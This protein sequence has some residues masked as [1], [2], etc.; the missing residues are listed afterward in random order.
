MALGSEARR[1]RAHG[2]AAA[3]DGR[4]VVCRRATLPAAAGD[5]A[6]S[7]GGSRFLTALLGFGAVASLGGFAWAITGAS[8]WAGSSSAMP[9]T[10]ATVND[11]ASP[12]RGPSQR[13]QPR[14]PAPPQRAQPKPITS[15]PPQMPGNP[16]APTA[17]SAK[18]EPTPQVPSVSA[19]RTQSS[20]Q[21]EQDRRRHTMIEADINARALAAARRNVSVQMYSTSWCRVCTEARNYMQQQNIAFVDHD[22]EQDEAAQARAHTL[23]PRN[24]VPV[25]EIEGDVMVGFNPRTFEA[26]LD[27][28]ARKRTGL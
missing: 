5:V 12:P 21:M 7:R 15:A 27:R 10:G 8:E 13:E 26:S 16:P 2:L 3:L 28:A 20:E 23:N 4:C 6:G 9:G 17:E 24:S 25:L 11:R 19:N 14:P 22:V 18:Q 1:C